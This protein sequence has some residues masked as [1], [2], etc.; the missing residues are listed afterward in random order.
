MKLFNLTAAAVAIGVADGQDGFTERELELNQRSIDMG[1]GRAAKFKESDGYVV[2]EKSENCWEACGSKRGWSG[3]CSF[4]SLSNGS[5]GFC[6][7]PRS[8]GGCSAGM[9]KAVRNSELR[10]KN[11]YQCIVPKTMDDNVMTHY[12]ML[13]RPNCWSNCGRKRGWAGRCSYCGPN[14][15]CCHADGRGGCTTEMADVLRVNRKRGMRCI[16][17]DTIKNDLRTETKLS[18]AC[19][20]V[21]KTECRTLADYKGKA[22]DFESL[23]DCTRF[24]SAKT[25]VSVDNMT[26][27]ENAKPICTT[28]ITNFC[29]SEGSQ[30]ATRMIDGTSDIDFAAS[31]QYET[32][33]VHAKEFYEFMRP[34][35]IGADGTSDKAACEADS[36]I[37]FNADAGTDH[38]TVPVNGVTGD[39]TLC[40]ND[41]ADVVALKAI[42]DSV[43]TANPTIFGKPDDDSKTGSQRAAEMMETFITA[44]DGWNAGTDTAASE[45]AQIQEIT[46]TAADRKS[47]V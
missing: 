1:E 41:R 37:V 21:H 30:R 19:K 3:F 8:N 5:P 40:D 36:S 33:P 9:V 45:S 38:L 31:G 7:N 20:D 17:P 43:T 35:W 25:C 44:L 26:I 11:H 13:D 34:Q 18:S 28:K 47:V 22:M 27:N 10:S 12:T 32:W 23:I 42:I 2:I 15:Y 4:C 46:D 14:G 29:A 16:V 6:C 24:F 39:L